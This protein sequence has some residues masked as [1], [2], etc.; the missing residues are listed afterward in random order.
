VE[1]GKK[2]KSNVKRKTTQKLEIDTSG[3]VNAK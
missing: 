3:K 2:G 1:N